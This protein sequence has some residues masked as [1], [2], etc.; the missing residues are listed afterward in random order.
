MIISGRK[1]FHLSHG[2][3]LKRVSSLGA[4]LRN[5]AGLST[6][7]AQQC[8]EIPCV[9]NE[10]KSNSAKADVPC[11]S[12][13]TSGRETEGHGV[14]VHPLSHDNWL[15]ACSQPGEDTRLNALSET[16]RKIYPSV[17]ACPLQ[18]ACLDWRLW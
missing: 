14:T 2:N 17:L 3:A 1:P 15:D 12:S 10:D 7:H 16:F 5:C 9:K 18:Q 8:Q 4:T 6:S 13:V 11:L